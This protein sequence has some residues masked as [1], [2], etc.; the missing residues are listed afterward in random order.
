MI[1]FL[2]FF[3]AFLTVIVYPLGYFLSRV[4]GSYK[5]ESSSLQV[6]IVPAVKIQ[7]FNRV[8]QP[9]GEVET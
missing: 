2:N 7:P 9:L 5:P 8:V 3:L 4:A 1:F 6:F